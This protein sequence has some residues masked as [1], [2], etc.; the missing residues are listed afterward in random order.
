MYY[1]VRNF[2]FNMRLE[3]IIDLCVNKAVGFEALSRLVTDD[4]GRE[5]FN[6]EFFFSGLTVDEHL[7]VVHAQLDIY[8]KWSEQHPE[9]YGERFLFVN[10]SPMILDDDD[11]FYTFIPYVNSYP[12]ALE[13][14]SHLSA[15]SKRAKENAKKL[16]S[17][18][19]QVWIDDYPGHGIISGKIWDGVKID[20]FAFQRGFDASMEGEDYNDYHR[21]SHVGPLVI[22]GIE[23]DEHLLYAKS[24]GAQ[25]GQGYLWSSDVSIFACN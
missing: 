7:S 4:V 10:V 20:R 23:S 1:K 24:I 3:P 21:V 14:D 13:I 25:F 22:E 6:Y 2:E 15:L 17:Y 5:A 19:I 9:I 11:A 12:I 16:Q 18:G 8:Q